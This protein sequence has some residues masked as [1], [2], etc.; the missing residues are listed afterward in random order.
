[1]FDDGSKNAPAA[2][3]DGAICCGIKFLDSDAG[4][5]ELSLVAEAGTCHDL[6]I[7]VSVLKNSVETVIDLQAPRMVELVEMS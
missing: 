3:P 1:L 6:G 4:P 2:E 7:S 5:R